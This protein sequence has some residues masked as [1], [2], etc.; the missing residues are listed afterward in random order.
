MTDNVFTK[1]INGEIPST[2]V[3]E[4]ERTYAFLDHNPKIPGHTLVI[5]KKQVEYV[6][7][8]S[9]DDYQ[10]L[11]TSVKKVAERIKEVLNPKYVGMQVE[12]IAVPHAHVHVFP[13]NNAEEFRNLPKP[14]EFLSEAELAEMGQKLAF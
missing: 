8:L 14:D 1:I 7:D 13:F 9:T 11:M 3:Y 4:D 6:W 10:A 12:G 2:K 5:P